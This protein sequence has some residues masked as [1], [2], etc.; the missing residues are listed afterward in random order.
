[1]DLVHFS[2][3]VKNN[4]GLKCYSAEIYFIETG[5]AKV[6]PF[7]GDILS[8]EAIAVIYTMY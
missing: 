8:C 2:S 6:I 5:F 7:H 4:C 3:T 1:M